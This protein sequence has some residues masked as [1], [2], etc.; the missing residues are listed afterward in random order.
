MKKSLYL[1]TLAI[2]LSIL[3]TGCG[4]LG[5]GQSSPEGPIEDPHMEPDPH[6]EP[7]PHMEPDPHGEPDP[8]ME[9]DPH[10]EPGQHEPEPHPEPPPPEPEPDGCDGPPTFTF[11]EAHPPTISPGQTAMI[12]WG[13]ITNGKNG[14]LVQFVE[15]SPGGFGEVGSPG[16][17]HVSP[18]ATT[19]YTLTATGCGGTKT[20]TV[21]V[22][23]QGSAQQQ[24]PQPQPPQPQPPQQPPGGGGGATGPP[25][26][27]QVVAYANPNSYT[28]PGPVKINFE[29]DITTNGPCTVTYRW[30]RSDGVQSPVETLIFNAAETKKVKDDWTIGCGGPG[31]GFL[32]ERVNIIT[33]LPMTSNN[34][35]FVLNCTN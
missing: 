1:V 30:E 13:P 25:H 12:E 14:P 27:T 9:P 19:T 31:T 18:S 16:S 28:G 3:L 33:P 15:L 26:V 32:W 23:V 4:F 10:A 2:L 34:G 20:K 6:G 22:E 8:H 24:P 29:A 21:T 11:F 35:E 17:R 7:D 5:F